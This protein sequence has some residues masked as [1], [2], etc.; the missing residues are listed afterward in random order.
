M[1]DDRRPMTPE[2]WRTLT[3][4]AQADDLQRV[5]AHLADEIREETSKS[6]FRDRWSGERVH[7]ISYDITLL[8]NFTSLRRLRDAPDILDAIRR[9]M[10]GVDTKALR[11]LVSAALRG[12]C[13]L[14]MQRRCDR[15]LAYC[16]A[17]DAAVALRGEWSGVAH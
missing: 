12:S 1:S 14:A 11:F 16:D 6:R 13:S 5:L 2:K 3:H 4:D 7:P 10:R 17:I 8:I 15:V 9:A